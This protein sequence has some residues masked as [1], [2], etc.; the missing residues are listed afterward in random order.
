VLP[1]FPLPG[2]HEIFP[3]R[4]RTRISDFTIAVDSTLSCLPVEEEEI[5]DRLRL[6]GTRC[7]PRVLCNIIFHETVQ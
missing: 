6:E 2:G 5:F 3:E 1:G 7:A 4:L